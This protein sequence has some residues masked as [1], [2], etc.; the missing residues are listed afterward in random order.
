[1]I[2]SVKI[3]LL[4]CLTGLVASVLVISYNEYTNRYE[5]ISTADNTLYI[6]DRKSTILNK[7]KNGECSVITTKL[8][9]IQLWQMGSIQDST[10]KQKTTNV[11]SNYSMRTQIQPSNNIN[12]VHN[13]SI[14]SNTQKEQN[15]QN[16]NA[17]SQEPSNQNDEFND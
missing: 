2:E 5:I 8:P 11:H 14:E 12:D 4:I 17:N 9:Q 16:I 1:M 15:Q 10:I 7:C 6:F 3:T 13:N